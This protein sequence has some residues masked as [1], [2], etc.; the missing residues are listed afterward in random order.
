MLR[1]FTLASYEN[2][3]CVPFQIHNRQYVAVLNYRNNN[4]RVDTDSVIYTFEGLQFVRYQSI[5]T[6]GANGGTYFEMESGQFLVIAQHYGQTTAYA[7]S[8]TVYKWDGV[9]FRVYQKLNTGSVSS[10]CHYII[11]SKHYLAFGRGSVT[12][13]SHSQVYVWNNTEFQFHQHITSHRAVNILPFTV[14][15]SHY[16]IFPSWQD[17]IDSSH[18]TNSFVLKW[19]GAQFELHQTIPTRGAHSTSVWRTSN[20]L[21]VSIAN[22]FEDSR[23][24]QTNS[25]IYIWRDGQLHK[26]RSIATNGG[27]SI[28]PFVVCGKQMIAVANRGL[29]KTV[30]HAMLSSQWLQQHEELRTPGVD[31]LAS[32]H[33][34]NHTYLVAST[35]SKSHPTL[36][37]QWAC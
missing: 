6:D 35:S 9:K 3:Q 30:V 10:A 20:S 23:G 12:I 24:Y 28:E 1:V 37:F 27:I 32:F 4:N 26:F 18:N 36:V 15:G 11:D 21:F 33:Y 34:N 7:V 16:L 17:A 29:G 13:H 19:S 2:Y 31:Q 25:E 5:Q 8:S 22:Y 14:D